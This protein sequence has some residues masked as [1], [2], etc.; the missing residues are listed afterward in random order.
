MQR[1]KQTVLRWTSL[2]GTYDPMRDANSEVLT[3]LLRSQAT[4]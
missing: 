1:N 3:G 4:G 2:I